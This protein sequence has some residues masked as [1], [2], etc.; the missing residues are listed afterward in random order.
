MPLQLLLLGL[1]LLVKERLHP[2]EGVQDSIVHG[3]RELH[4]GGRGRRGVLAVLWVC[5]VG[6]RVHLWHTL[7][8]K[9]STLLDSRD[10]LQDV[11]GHDGKYVAYA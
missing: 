8:E 7:I 4:G 11:V 10:G 5:I 6:K 1:L 9:I 3:S 2:P